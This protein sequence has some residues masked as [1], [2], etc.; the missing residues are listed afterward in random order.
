M[1][2]ATHFRCSDF[3]SSRAD[4]CTH[5][6]L[7]YTCRYSGTCNAASIPRRKILRDTE[8]YRSDRSSRQST[9]KLLQ[10]KK[11]TV[12]DMIYNSSIGK[13]E[14]SLYTYRLHDGNRRH[15][16]NS[17]DSSSPGRRSST[18]TDVR[19]W[20]QCTRDDTLSHRSRGRTFSDPLKLKQKLV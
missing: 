13:I 12:K 1:Y 11:T 16:Y 18:D 2:S 17:N 19:T 4:I 14:R 7:A 5:H 20:I 8:M 3:Q 9:R 15:F 10:R 6:R